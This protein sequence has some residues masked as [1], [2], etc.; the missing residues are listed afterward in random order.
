MLGYLFD[1]ETNGVDPYKR[2]S[3]HVDGA[4]SILTGIAGN[5]SIATGQT[6]DVDAMLAKA[7]IDIPRLFA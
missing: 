6:V 5:E 7:G 3:T 2:G 4:W 1:A